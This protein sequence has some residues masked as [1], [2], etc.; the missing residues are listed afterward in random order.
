MSGHQ[1][2]KEG[3]VAGCS[4]EDR[5]TTWYTHFRD[6]LF[7]LPRMEGAEEEITKS[8]KSAGP[9]SIPPAVL[10]NCYLNH[11]SGDLQPGSDRKHQARYMVSF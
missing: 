7:T 1:R 10:K 2:S 4:P 6:L 3:Q 11:R 5:V 9:D 8:V